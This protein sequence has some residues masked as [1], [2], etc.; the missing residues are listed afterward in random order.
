M[1]P[2]LRINR[3][4]GQ[5][6]VLSLLKLKSLGQKRLARSPGLVRRRLDV[7]RVWIGF[8]FVLLCK[9]LSGHRQ[10]GV[11]D[12]KRKWAVG[13]ALD[14][15]CATPLGRRLSEESGNAAQ[16]PPAVSLGAH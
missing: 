8:V 4:A 7:K 1:L 14:G 10:R 6:A 3:P 15:Q 11:L 13:S 9:A 2:G 16:A 5:V 12:R